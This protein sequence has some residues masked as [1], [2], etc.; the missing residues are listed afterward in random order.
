MQLI[1]WVENEYGRVLTAGSTADGHGFAH[2]NTSAC[3]GN[4]HACANLALISQVLCAYGLLRSGGAQRGAA[5]DGHG[6]QARPQRSGSFQL[7]EATVDATSAVDSG[8]SGGVGDVGGGGSRENTGCDA[9]EA[10]LASGGSACRDAE[11]AAIGL[12]RRDCVTASCSQ[13]GLLLAVGS[14]QAVQGSSRACATGLSFMTAA[15]RL[16][17]HLGWTVWSTMPSSRSNHYKHMES[18]ASCSTA[19]WHLHQ[20]IN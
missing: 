12:S 5:A 11:H 17:C 1:S 9:A 14:G 10:S 8:A 4:V 2:V 3:K 16:A 7:P 19:A 13:S 18:N 15:P 20:G 6:G